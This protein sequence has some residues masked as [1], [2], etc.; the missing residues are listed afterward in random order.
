ML[1]ALFIFLGAGIKILAD[2]YCGLV[3]KICLNL[4]G[5]GGI[6]QAFIEVLGMV[7]GMA[8]YY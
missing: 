3:V 6:D 8:G 2:V 4:A 5:A 1:V 7:G